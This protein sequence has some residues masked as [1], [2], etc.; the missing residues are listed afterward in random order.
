MKRLRRPTGGQW[1]GSR[2][3]AVALLKE[4]ISGGL[5]RLQLRRPSPRARLTSLQFSPFIR[6]CC[7]NIHSQLDAFMAT[8]KVDHVATLRRHLSG[9]ATADRHM[10]I[11]SV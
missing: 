3:T 4:R 1:A 8:V 7:P 10:Q 9:A 11:H 5:A 2:G 6:L